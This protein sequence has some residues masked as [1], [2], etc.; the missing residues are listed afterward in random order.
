MRITQRQRFEARLTMII[1]RYFSKRC[2]RCQA[3]V[4]AEGMWKFRWHGERAHWSVY[5]CLTCIPT[6]A[7][8]L[9]HFADQAGDA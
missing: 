9:K 2:G 5:L 3:D 1:V 4:W 8:A 6:R 7:E